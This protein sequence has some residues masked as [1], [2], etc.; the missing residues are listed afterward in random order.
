P[1]SPEMFKKLYRYEGYHPSCFENLAKNFALFG[2]EGSAIPT[3]FNIFMNVSVLPN[4]ELKIGPPLSRPGDY[5]I[6]QAEMDVIVGLTACSAELSNN[7]TFKPIDAEV[8]G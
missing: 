6:L 3:T 2:I 8:F 5:I 1:C 4:G 7:A